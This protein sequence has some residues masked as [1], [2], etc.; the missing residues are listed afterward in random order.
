MRR[1]LRL[2]PTYRALENAVATYRHA[3]ETTAADRDRLAKETADLRA[4]VEILSRTRDQ[5]DEALWNCVDPLDAGQFRFDILHEPSPNDDLLAPHLDSWQAMFNRGEH[6]LVVKEMLEVFSVEIGLQSPPAYFKAY[7]AYYL[8][9]ILADRGDFK[10]AI[11]FADMIDFDPP[12]GDA[13]LPNDLRQSGRLLRIRQDLAVAKGRPGAAIVSLVR[14]ASASLTN[15]IASSFEIPIFKMSVGNAM[16]SVVVPGWA[17]QLARGGAVTHEHFRA[18]PINLEALRKAGVRALWVQVRDPR[19][20]AFSLVQMRAAQPLVR[21]PSSAAFVDDCRT[22][23]NW[24]DE[25]IAAR[26]KSGIDISFIT[27]ANVCGDLARTMTRIFRGQ[28]PNRFIT[29]TVN[30]RHGTGGEWRALD[31]VSRQ[32]A[33]DA[34]PAGVKNL[35]GLEF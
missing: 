31:A 28:Q 32:R 4:T 13:L 22:L 14:S 8:A 34:I 7:A 6:D 33:W 27:F 26:E 16:Q 35:L 20:A 18:I 9:S 15:T 1:M 21:Q 19:D 5:L 25:W 24:I 30:F 11:Q 17:A 12:N 3:F 2:F 23:A 29:Q 10:R